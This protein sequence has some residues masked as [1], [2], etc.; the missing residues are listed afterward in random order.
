MRDP[1]RIPIAMDDIMHVW[2]KFHDL[3]LGQII[4]SAMSGSDVDLFYIEDDE[5]VDRIQE[6]FKEMRYGSKNNS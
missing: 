5:L 1:K 3:R 2:E 6:K 4:S